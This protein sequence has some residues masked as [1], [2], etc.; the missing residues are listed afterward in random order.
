MEI[1]KNI[2]KEK[3]CIFSAGQCGSIKCSAFLSK[4]THWKSEI[5]LQNW[6]QKG[7]PFCLPWVCWCFPL[8]W[9]W[10]LSQSTST[11]KSHQI[12]A[13]STTLAIC[14]DHGLDTTRCV[15]H[16]WHMD[17]TWAAHGHAEIL[18]D[19]AFASLSRRA[20][21]VRFTSQRRIHMATITA[22][23]KCKEFEG[24]SRN[25]E[26]NEIHNSLNLWIADICRGVE[27][28]LHLSPHLIFLSS[29]HIFSVRCIMVH[30]GC[31]M[32]HHGAL[33]NV[34]VR[35]VDKVQITRP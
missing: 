12:C 13:K 5:P 6:S 22:T 1:F 21:I 27:S 16:G 10:N 8:L 11:T 28:S 29:F 26:K 4:L 9:N 3:R 31:I 7:C 24:N 19:L 17:D 30:H 20:A 23:K 33:Y 25:F 18:S 34:L 14:M 2:L 32:V 35:S 15:E